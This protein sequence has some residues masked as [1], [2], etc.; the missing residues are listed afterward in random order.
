MSAARDHGATRRAQLI[1][2]GDER[3]H[4]PQRT[5]RGGAQQRAELRLEDLLH[6]ETQ[7]DAAQSE[8]RPGAVD[9]GVMDRQL[10]LADV[11]GPDRDRGSRRVRHQPAVGG[12]LRLF[13]ERRLSATRQQELGTE[14]PDALRPLFVRAPGI[15]RRLDVRF[16]PDLDAVCSDAWQPTV[17]IE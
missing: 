6:R 4:D 13:R 2:A 17:L 9:A 3:K 15:V 14:E 7:T 10:R 12:V 1:D 11:E 16:E 5:V 8:R